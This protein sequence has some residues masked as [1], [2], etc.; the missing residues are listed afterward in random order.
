M[1]S[2]NITDGISEAMNEQDEEFGEERI[3]EIVAEH[4]Q[5]NRAGAQTAHSGGSPGFLQR[6]L[7]G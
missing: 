4:H 5:K 3:A 2:V 7:R 6:Q 1:P